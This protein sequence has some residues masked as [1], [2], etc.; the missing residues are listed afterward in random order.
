MR[1]YSTL[2]FVVKDEANMMALLHVTGRQFYN[3]ADGDFLR[4]FRMLKMKMK[5]G[6]ECWQK[7]KD[8]KVLVLDSIEKTIEEKL[9]LAS[10]QISMCVNIDDG[11]P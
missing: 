4:I 9:T 2:D 1:R 5:M 3:Q 6:Y 8:F 11:V 7:G 10:A